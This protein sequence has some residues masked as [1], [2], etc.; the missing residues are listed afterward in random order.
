MKKTS[1]STISR[2]SLVPSPRPFFVF[3]HRL[4]LPLLF[5]LI[6]SL[7]FSYHPRIS[8]FSLPS[9]NLELS[10]PLIFL[11]LFALIALPS[12][13]SRLKGIL[14][15]LHSS[16]LPRILRTHPKSFLIILFS[17]PLYLIISTFWSVHFLRAI[18][19]SGIIFCLTVT[20][21]TIPIIIISQKTKNKIVKIYLCSSAFVALFCWLQSFL[22]VLSPLSLWLCP[23]CVFQTFGFPHPSGFAIEPQFMGNLLLA[24][25]FLS[26]FLFAKYKKK[27]Y[28]ILAFYL[29][30]TLFLVYSR[31]ATYS[32]FLGFFL[33]ILVELFSRR[34]LRSLV[35]SALVL[36]SLLTSFLAQGLLSALSPTN[37]TFLSGITKSLHHFSLG[38]ID[39]RIPPPTP[40]SSNTS[41]LSPADPPSPSS[42]SS[43][44]STIT[45]EPSLAS[46]PAAHF[47]GYVAE[48]TDIRL[49]LNQ[50]ALDRWNDHPSSFL[51]GTGLGSAGSV[52]Y[53]KSPS[54]GSPKEIVQNQYLSLLLETGALGLALF[55]CLILLLSLLTYF[56]SSR[57]ATPYLFA[58][59]LSFTLSLNF[60]SG[61]P[62]ALHLYLL[63]V[64][65]LCLSSHFKNQK[66]K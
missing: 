61:L 21:L 44:S 26:F 29:L 18:L 64:F 23:G 41:V 42:P 59:F 37:D 32:F 28:L 40:Q 4:E 2:T 8:L 39:L 27:K 62:N 47:S 16:S 48:S 24:P 11:F 20:I 9:M 50:I 52:L 17:F 30:S 46:P 25:V 60:F 31:G 43:S 35:F 45:T 22:N 51:F 15:F 5:L 7:F 10:L 49:R 66:A 12:L 6:P 56:F 1:P 33:L 58:L 65:F 57:P 36:C 63:P 54:L 19:T 3:L 13:P 14:D 38:R 34:F 53:Q 55:L